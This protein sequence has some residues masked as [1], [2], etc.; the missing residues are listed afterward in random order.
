MFVSF[1]TV[2]DVSFKAIKS[3]ASVFGRSIKAIVSYND[4]FHLV[5]GPDMNECLL[6]ALPRLFHHSLSP[7]LFVL[8]KGALTSLC[9]GAGHSC[10]DHTF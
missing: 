9:C 5:S 3:V 2:S 8:E 1:V 6:H 7:R 4:L 10:F